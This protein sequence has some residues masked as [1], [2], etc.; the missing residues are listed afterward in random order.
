MENTKISFIMEPVLG[1]GPRNVFTLSKLLSDSGL[2][3]NVL[4][5]GV[6]RYYNYISKGSLNHNFFGANRFEPN[7]LLSLANVASSFGDSLNALVYPI[8]ILDQFV[9]KPFT[10]FK[11]PKPTIYIATN[12]QSF[13]PTLRVSKGFG[14]PMMYFVQADE[15]EFK[16]NKIYKKHATKTYLNDIQKFTHS[17]WLVEEFDNKFGVKLNY[18][19]FGIDHKVFFPREITNEKI[20]LTIARTEYIKGFPVFVKAVNRLW[21]MRHDFKVIIAGSKSA[22]NKETINFPYEFLGWVKSDDLLAKLYSRSIFVNTGLKEA[23]P[24]PPLEAMACGGCIIMS[25]NGGSVEYTKDMIN[26]LLTKPGDDNELTEKLNFILSNDS[27]REELRNEA[28]KTA[29]KYDWRYVV[30]NLISLISEET[31]AF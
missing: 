20:I 15:T 21:K 6:N 11:Y 13:S 24:M 1:G 7:R 14:I 29:K 8:F 10:I 23:L 4:S 9:V 22:V 2:N 31:S 19:G 27:V 16:S 5:F 3:S 28:I 18:I 17:K 12:W 25:S 26:C 30:N